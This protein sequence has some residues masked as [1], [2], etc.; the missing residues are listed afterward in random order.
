M[1]YWNSMKCLISFNSGLR[2]ACFE[3]F[4]MLDVNVA[5]AL[6]YQTDDRENLLNRAMFEAN[7]GSGYI[8]KP[9][10]LREP[11]HAY[12]PLTS[13]HMDRSLFPRLALTID[14]MSGAASAPLSCQKEK[15]LTNFK[16]HLI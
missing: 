5:V 6:N 14:I 3:Y 10:F 1:N 11:G 12:S 15:Y 4:E 8:L 9:L 16:L 2:Y 13:T 7:G